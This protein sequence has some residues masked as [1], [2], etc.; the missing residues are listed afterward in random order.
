[1]KIPVP[2][3]FDYE[4]NTK[5]RLSYQFLIFITTIK[6]SRSYLFLL[7]AVEI[8]MKEKNVPNPT[9]KKNT[10][11]FIYF[12]SLYNVCPLHRHIL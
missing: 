7:Q 8:Q 5:Y 11:V 6:Y 12:R 3:M 10:N 9:G 4:K 2:S 1:M